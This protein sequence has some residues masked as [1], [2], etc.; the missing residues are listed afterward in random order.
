MEEEKRSSLG[1]LFCSQCH[2][3]LFTRYSGTE[4]ILY[5]KLCQREERKADSNDTLRYED[6]TET[7]TFLYN[8]IRE[9]L[10]LD[11]VALKGLR[12]CPKCKKTVFVKQT[13]VDNDMHLINKCL[14]CLHVWFEV[15][16]ENAVLNKQLDDDAK[17][18]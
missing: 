9:T 8:T 18:T 6:V 12:D 16:S 13:C 3:F 11:P 4:M 5:C 10:H 1:H 2:N 17:H 15:R 7:M 14:E